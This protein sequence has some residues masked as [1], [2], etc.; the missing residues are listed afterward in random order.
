MLMFRACCIGFG[1]GVL[2]IGANQRIIRCRV[3]V[4]NELIT[5]RIHKRTIDNITV[6]SAVL[7]PVSRAQMGK[8][9]KHTAHKNTFPPPN[10]T[11]CSPQP[12]PSD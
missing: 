4:V 1:S 2:F 7:K 6:C 3:F 5:P 10:P 11:S 9:R 8:Y 12:K